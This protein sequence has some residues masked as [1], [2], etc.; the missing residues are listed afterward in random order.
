MNSLIVERLINDP[1]KWLVTGSAGFIGSNL[2]IALLELNQQVVGIDNFSS[3]S[4]SNLNY[5]KNQ[6]TEYQWQRFLFFEGDVCNSR[7]C[8]KAIKTV[9][10]VLHHASS[11]SVLASINNPIE[12][13][14]LNVSGFL[15][16]LLAAC[17][18]NVKRFVYASS[19]SVYGN[20]F[21]R[22]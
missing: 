3:G 4:R 20:N 19:S 7:L 17:E 8:K 22:L 1:K 9:D 16:I 14:H 21:S 18:A 5:V 15:N 10:Y 2:T 13:N 12:V 11:T 6:V